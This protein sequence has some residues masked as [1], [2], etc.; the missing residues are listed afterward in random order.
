AFHAG[1]IGG[2][3][4]A[5]AAAAAAVQSVAFASAHVAALR[6]LWTLLH[7]FILAWGLMLAVLGRQ[8]MWAH[9]AGRLLATR[10]RL[11]T[12][13]VLGVVATGAL[14]VSMPCGLLYSALMLAGLANGLVQGAFAMAMFAAGSALSLVLAPW[15]WQRLRGGLGAS[16]KEWG[17]RLAGMALAAVTLQALGIDLGRPIRAWCA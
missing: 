4:A 3:A 17:T 2:Y 6:S 12:G 8:P 1:R 15:L 9:R 13:S 11:L 10:L 16:R 14:W 7:V 5:G